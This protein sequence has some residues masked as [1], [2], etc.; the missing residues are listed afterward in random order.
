MQEERNMTI[1]DALQAASA[2]LK[3]SN[4]EYPIMEAQILLAYVL[5][6]DRL[7]LHVHGRDIL[8]LQQMESYQNLTEA[9]CRNTPIAYLT[10]SKEF[11]SLN[12]YVDERVLIPRPD[13]E[14]LAEE[15]IRIASAF[16]NPNMLDLCCGSGCIGLSVAYNMP[17]LHAV[18]SDISEDALNIARIN[19][20]THHLN[21]RIELIQSDLFEKMDKMKF[22]LIV[23]NPP[24]ITDEAMHSLS[25]EIL[26]YEPQSALRGG[27]DGLRFYR[28][29]I[30][31]ASRYLI[32][33]GYL[34]L[35]IGYDQADAVKKIMQYNGYEDIR[36]LHDYAGHDRVVCGTLSLAMRNE[37]QPGQ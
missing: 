34:L 2:A 8:T 17:K 36:V 4:I 33:R 11:M 19:T 27:T 25:E 37:P 5:D 32:P 30:A 35:E 23:S 24:Y 6:V 22:H 14:I 21:D 13:T 9:R 12:F 15:A 31:Q 20:D 29:I 7:Y 16:D 26:T 3:Q 28:D 18:L 1:Q 10:H